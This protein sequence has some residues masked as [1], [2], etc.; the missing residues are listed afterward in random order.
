MQTRTV[1]PSASID[2]RRASESWPPPGI[3]SAP[4]ARAPSNPAQKPTKS[5]N[6]NG[7]K[8]RSAGVTPAARSTKAQQRVHQSHDACV[9]SQR[10][11]SALVPDVW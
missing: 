6:E 7:K 11:G 5:P 3:A 2:A 8:T 1:A 4:S 9:S 10:M